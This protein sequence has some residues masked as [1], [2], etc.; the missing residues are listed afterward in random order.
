MAWNKGLLWQYA[1]MW[2]IKLEHAEQCDAVKIRINDVRQTEI[3][4]AK[5]LIPEPSLLRLR[6]LLESWKGMWPGTD[7]FLVEL[8]QAG[9]SIFCSDIYR[10]INSIGNKE[11]LQ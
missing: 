8:I 5:P 11:A 9:G 10:S 7:Q 4:T 3:H 6:L 2:H 1:R